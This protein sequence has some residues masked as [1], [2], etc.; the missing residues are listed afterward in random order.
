[1]DKYIRMLAGEGIELTV[2][3]DLDCWDGRV[4]LA[5]SNTNKF[6]VLGEQ[7]FMVH[8]KIFDNEEQAKEFYDE[9][10]EALEG[11]IFQLFKE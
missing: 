6:S 5:K 1:M 4:M 3:E 7:Y 10:V 2:I 11:D 8:S 9:V